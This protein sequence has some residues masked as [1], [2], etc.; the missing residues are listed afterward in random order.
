MKEKEPRHLADSR[1]LIYNL[2]SDNL[3][4]T[5]K[6]P[7]PLNHTT[8]IYSNI[9]VDDTDSDCENAFA[10]VANA[11][12]NKPNLLVFSLKKNES[13]AVEHVRDIK[14]DTFPLILLFPHYFNSFL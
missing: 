2:T 12:A 11:G 10:F 14:I 8:S 5:Y 3:I 7:A 4:R 6:L 9:V 13:W 1:I